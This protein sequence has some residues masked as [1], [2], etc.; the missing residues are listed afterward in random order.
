MAQETSGDRER[1]GLAGAFALCALATLALLAS[2]PT[3]SARTL[4][5]VLREEAQSV[6]INGVVHGGFIITL[7]ALM[8]CFKLLSRRLGSRRLSVAIALTAFS[9][10][11]GLLIA[12]MILDGIVT[13][14][15]A[16]RFADAGS[17]DNLTMART[18]FILCGTVI[19]FLMPIGMLFQST[20]IVC[21]SA[22]IVK[23]PG[24]RRGVGAS[25]LAAGVT[26]IIGLLAVPPALKP[27]LLLAGIALQAM[28]YLALAALLTSGASWPVA[29]R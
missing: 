13:P 22:A 21:W 10:G 9:I 20:A 1:R 19:S 18:L 12:S 14:A 3:G 17:A 23:G 28:W 25:G 6:W 11:S 15:L 24:V 27:H 5:D 29:E 26:L 4:A 8:V 7:A 2:H 16:V